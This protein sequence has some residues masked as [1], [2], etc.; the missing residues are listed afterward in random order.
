M[1]AGVGESALG[2]HANRRDATNTR[3]C[4]RSGRDAKK[5]AQP[6]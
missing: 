3:I 6:E 4:H 1:H 5:E 2:A